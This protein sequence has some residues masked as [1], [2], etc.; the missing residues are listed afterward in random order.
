[1]HGRTHRD[2]LENITSRLSKTL[3]KLEEPSEEAWKG[4]CFSGRSGIWSVRHARKYFK[5]MGHFS[6]PKTTGVILVKVIQ[7]ILYTAFGTAH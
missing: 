5:H 4:G 7:S 2:R 3:A 1:M 6:P